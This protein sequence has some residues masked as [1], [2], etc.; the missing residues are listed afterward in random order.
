ML[1]LLLWLLLFFVSTTAAVDKTVGN[2]SCFTMVMTNWFWD[3]E[4]NVN[5]HFMLLLLPLLLLM[6]LV[7]LSLLLLYQQQAAVLFAH[8]I[9]KTNGC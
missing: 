9:Q 6:M 5:H 1:S 8:C 4:R 2:N 7:M 3:T